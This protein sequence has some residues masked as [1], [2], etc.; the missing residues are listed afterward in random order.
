M[1]NFICDTQTHVK[2]LHV[3]DHMW[4][5]IYDHS[6]VKIHMWIFTCEFSHVR[7]S[8]EKIHMWNFTCEKSHVKF[9]MWNFTCEISHVK[10]HMWNFTCEISHV[11]SSHMWNFTCD[12][13]HVTLHMWNTCETHIDST[14]VSH[15]KLIPCETHGIWNSHVFLELHMCESHVSDV[16]NFC[17][18]ATWA[19][20]KTCCGV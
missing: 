16:R 20:L 9:H 12:F 14:C 4:N 13:S 11:K 15:V 2:F 17:K 10:F 3:K 7:I 8:H 6:H 1:W 5:F 19:S 18:G